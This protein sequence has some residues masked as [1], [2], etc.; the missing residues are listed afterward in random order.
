[1]EKSL[2]KSFFWIRRHNRNLGMN[3]K[4]E[5]IGVTRI[6]E[7]LQS[8]KKQPDAPAEAVEIEDIAAKINALEEQEKEKKKRKR[9]MQK[10][11]RRALR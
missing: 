9:E 2:E 7:K 6:K 5:K 3:M 4:V 11:R 8:L 1:M 10:K